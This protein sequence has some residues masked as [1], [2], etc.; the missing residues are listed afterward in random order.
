MA[1]YTDIEAFVV[2]KT[3]KAV[4]VQFH[5]DTKHE[6]DEIWVPF[7]HLEDPDAVDEV[8]SDGKVT[9]SVKKWVLKKHDVEYDSDDLED[10]ADTMATD[11][12]FRG[13]HD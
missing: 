6:S 2:S 5:P 3:D 4:C 9:L 8:D 1:A 12:K 13:Q 11:T 7:A 10:E